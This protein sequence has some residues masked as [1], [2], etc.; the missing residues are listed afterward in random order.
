M[1]ENNKEIIKDKTIQLL[2]DKKKQNSIELR[3]IIKQKKIEE[4]KKII[5]KS[6]KIT[7]YIP[8]KVAPE[9]TARRN[10]ALKNIEE[11]ILAINKNNSLE[12]EFNELVHY[13]DDL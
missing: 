1:N 13:S 12:N 8:N 7:A 11:K 3:E 9:S 6:N 4:I 10:K 2:L 5:E